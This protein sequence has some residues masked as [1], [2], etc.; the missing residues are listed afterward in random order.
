MIC[1]ATLDVADTSSM[2][3]TVRV[4]E[5]GRRRKGQGDSD[6]ENDDGDEEEDGADEDE[7]VGVEVWSVRPRGGR[8]SMVNGAKSLI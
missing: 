6:D 2:S 8:G 7:E 1:L 4:Y 3:S 5:V